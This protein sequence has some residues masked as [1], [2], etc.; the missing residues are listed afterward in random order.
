MIQQSL[1]GFPVKEVEFAGFTRNI[2]V[3]TWEQWE[4]DRIVQF[5]ESEFPGCKVNGARVSGN[6]WTLEVTEIDPDILSLTCA[7]DSDG[8]SPKTS[9]VDQPTRNK[10]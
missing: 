9:P 10:E 6:T 7:K 2:E 3:Q 1:I 4:R 8:N 5:V